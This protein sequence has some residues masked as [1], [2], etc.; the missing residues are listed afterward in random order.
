MGPWGHDSSYSHIVGER[1]LGVAGAGEAFGLGDRVLDFYDAALAGAPARPRAGHRLP[2]RRT[3]LGVAPRLAAAGRDGADG[4]RSI[5]AGAF[6]VD[7]ADLPPTLGGRALLVG[8]FLNGIGARDQRAVAARDDVLAL[9]L[10]GVGAGTVLAG[11]VRAHLRRRGRAA[12][13][14]ATGP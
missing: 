13:R 11:P 8:L 3:P 6:D 2:A 4:R 12:A 10:D 5:G 9:P 7:P 1:H 14:R